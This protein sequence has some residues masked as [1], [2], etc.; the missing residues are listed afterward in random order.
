M[1][2]GCN[3]ETEAKPRW[4]PISNAVRGATDKHTK[5]LREL[6][7]YGVNVNA[8]SKPTGRTPPHYAI[9]KAPWSGYSSVIYILLAARADPDA[10]DKSNDVPLLMLLAGGGPLPQEKRDAL[11]LLLAPNPATNLDVSIPGTLDNPLHLA[12]RRK[13][14]Y[15]VDV[16]LEKMQQVRGRALKLIHKYNGSG[17]T[18]LLLAFTIFSLLGEEADE[19]LQ[20][21]KLLLEHGANPNDKDVAHGGTPLHL[22]VCASKNSIALEL[23]YQ[24]SANATLPNNAGNSAID[25]ANKLRSGNPKDKWYLFAK[26]RMCNIEG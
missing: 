22:V 4:A 20:I 15:T 9:E 6:V 14:A 23:F 3:P 17:F 5:C 10:R 19:E 16:I 7:S 13:D 2:A 18:P 25:V 11:Y 12:V 8:V 26:R 1:S 21:I 24:H